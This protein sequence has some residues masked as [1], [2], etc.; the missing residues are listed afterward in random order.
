MEI[1]E[2]YDENLS[3]DYILNGKAQSWPW[4]LGS[5]RRCIS[6]CLCVFP[7]R[8]LN[9]EV[10]RGG[11]LPAAT[12]VARFRGNGSY[13]WKAA[14]WRRLK[15]R[16]ANQG[17][18]E[19]GDDVLAGAVKTARPRWLSQNVMKPFSDFFV[20]MVPSH[21]LD[22]LRNIQELNVPLFANHLC[23]SIALGM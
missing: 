13:G 10:T 14:C 21:V 19:S 3:H 9:R 15:V 22:H 4:Q 20:D 5:M 23:C 1:L 11:S 8:G 6:P 16:S 12:Q 17:F 18:K 2:W 7:T